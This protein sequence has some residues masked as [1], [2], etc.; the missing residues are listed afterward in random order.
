MKEWAGTMA[1]FTFLFVVALIIAM[2]IATIYANLQATRACLSHGYPDA[3]VTA[4]FEV[5]CIRIVD[6]TQ[7]VIPLS[8]F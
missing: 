3:K 7:Q 4:T 6:Q 2:L 8:D 5:Y 1:L